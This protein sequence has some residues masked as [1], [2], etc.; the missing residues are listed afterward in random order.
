MA[1]ASRVIRQ[2]N[3]SIG[4]QKLNS[5]FSWQV[6]IWLLHVVYLLSQQ[7]KSCDFDTCEWNHFSMDSIVMT[8]FSHAFSWACCTAFRSFC[9]GTCFLMDTT[10]SVMCLGVAWIGMK[11]VWKV[12]AILMKIQEVGS[13]SQGQLEE[14]HAMGWRLIDLWW[15]ATLTNLRNVAHDGSDNF[16]FIQIA[17]CAGLL[18]YSG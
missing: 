3:S 15:R 18:T 17:Y 4:T 13:R 1:I 6:G 12:C 14:G 10:S 16:N 11:N 8:R 2:S 7:R 9:Q 5:C